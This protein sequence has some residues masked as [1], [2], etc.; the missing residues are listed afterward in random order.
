MQIKLKQNLLRII[1][2]IES[3]FADPVRICEAEN[4]LMLQLLQ[5]KNGVASQYRDGDIVIGLMIAQHTSSNQKKCGDIETYG[6]QVMET[7]NMLIEKVLTQLFFNKSTKTLF[8]KICCI[9]Y[10][11]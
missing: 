5:I 3:R 10:R 7:V 11:G 2:K 4:I 1:S 8:W 6:V 9:C